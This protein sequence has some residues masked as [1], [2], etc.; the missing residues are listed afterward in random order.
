MVEAIVMI[1]FEFVTK[2]TCYL[3]YRWSSW[4]SFRGWHSWNAGS[5]TA[6]REVSGWKLVIEESNSKFKEHSIDREFYLPYSTNLYFQ[7][8]ESFLVGLFN[9]NKITKVNYVL[10]YCRRL[11]VQR[12]KERTEAHLYVTVE[13][14]NSESIARYTVCCLLTV[15]III[16]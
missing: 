5:E 14:H 7:V 16:P 3:Q 15:I 4:R 12:R 6:G 11:E 13:V 10:N 9:S 8:C 1:T 2:F